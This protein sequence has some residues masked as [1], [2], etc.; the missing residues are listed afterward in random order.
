MTK[1][2]L[3]RYTATRL[4]LMVV[5]T[6]FLAACAGEI[7]SS[8]KAGLHPV[9]ANKALVG[10]VDGVY[11]MTVDPGTSQSMALGPSH[12]DLPAGS[13]CAIGTSGYGPSFWDAPCTPEA[14]PVTIT[15]IVRN[16][17]TNHPSVEFQ[18]ALRFN[19]ATPVKLYL[20]VT[21]AATLTNMA[22][23]L[24]CGPFS[25]ICVD[26]SVS[27]ASLTTQINTS[28]NLVWRRIKHFSGYMVSE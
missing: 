28:S 21:D 6:M 18:P 26:E 13:I 12:L 10:V 5:A 16:A 24:Y 20:Y 11:T 1:P 19:P 2:T 4:S 14:T 15:A 22:T 23:V 7:P 25:A 3:A 17:S 27:D 8:P 9:D